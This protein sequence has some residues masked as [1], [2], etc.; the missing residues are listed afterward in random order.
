[1][2]HTGRQIH[3]LL[4]ALEGRE[5]KVISVVGGGGK[6]S[7]LKRLARE[8]NALHR[9]VIV[10][11]TTRLAADEGLSFAH[12]VLTHGMPVDE[13]VKSQAWPHCDVLLVGAEIGAG[14][15]KGIRTEEVDWLHRLFPHKHVLVEADGSAK[16]PFK[17]PAEHEPVVPRSTELVIVIVGAWAFGLPVL[18]EYIHRAQLVA[19]FAGI[20]LGA[21][22]TARAAARALLHPASYPKCL[23]EGAEMVVIINGIDAANS[24]EAQRF[25]RE[26]REAG[27][28]RVLL[29]NV[30]QEP[31]VHEV[32]A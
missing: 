1:M 3:S 15:L 8:F 32:I 19:E 24:E 12:R 26:L 2:V 17:V 9:E 14:K 13:W 21:P 31:P 4:E 29:A 28:K 25:G 22:L 10:T 18:P 7:T 6:T 16:K 30:S 11:T 5:A 23:P 27:V 20:S